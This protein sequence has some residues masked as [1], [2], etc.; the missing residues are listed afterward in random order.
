VVESGYDIHIANY[1]S[2]SI[3]LNT[4]IAPNWLEL[5]KKT[6]AGAVPQ[7]IRELPVALA[8]L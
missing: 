4:T 7:P 2:G 1:G 5:A 8:G 6:T 3:K